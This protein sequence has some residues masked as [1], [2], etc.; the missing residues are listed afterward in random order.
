[1]VCVTTIVAS[2]C[3][4]IFF[5]L[6]VALDTSYRSVETEILLDCMIQ[7]PN[8]GVP[9]PCTLRSFPSITLYI[10]HQERNR[11]RIQFVLSLSLTIRPMMAI[12]KPANATANIEKHPLGDKTIMWLCHPCFL[13]K[14]RNGTSRQI[15][16][17]YLVIAGPTYTVLNCT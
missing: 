2:V 16:R 11:S 12:A 4:C 13:L 6:F 1:M 5:N 15:Q 3:T 17:F 7:A 9:V 8:I 10:E 14:G